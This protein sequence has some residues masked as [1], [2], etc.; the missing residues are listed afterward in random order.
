MSRYFISVDGGGTKTEYA[1]LNLDT[2]EVKVTFDKGSN[3][4]YAN[5]TGH[6]KD[7]ASSTTA[8][9][10]SENID[11]SEIEKIVFGLSGCDSQKDYDYL[12]G[13]IRKTGIP[14]EKIILMNDCEFG[15]RGIV[16]S[17]GICVVTGTGSITYGINGDLNVR[18]AGWGPPYSDLGSGTWIGAE[19]IKEAILRLDDSV[20]DEIT[21]VVRHFQNNEEP[22]QQTLNAFDIP[23]TASVAVDCTRLAQK[24]NETCQWIVKEA[25]GHIANYI[26]RC[27]RK[28]EFTGD[29]LT[30]VCVGGIYN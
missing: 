7:I 1:I 27:F 26:A 3:F 9:L 18:D 14:D 22:L 5:E 21:E 25:A 29:E 11:V 2:D 19:F 4:K 13:V 15:L 17:V 8:M 10:K 20:E 6:T 12:L 23:S 24:G 28:L 16:E 30:I